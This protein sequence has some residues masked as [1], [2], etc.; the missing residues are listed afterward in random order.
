MLEEHLAGPMAT[1]T[2]G[3]LGTTA[4]GAALSVHHDWS[5]PYLHCCGLVIPALTIASLFY[6]IR[7]KRKADWLQ[8]KEVADRKARE[9]HYARK[10]RLKE[11]RKRNKS[12]TKPPINGSI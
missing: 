1:A 8:D 11:M 9:A 10:R 4:V 6:D 2:K 12:L 7:K 5:A 3:V